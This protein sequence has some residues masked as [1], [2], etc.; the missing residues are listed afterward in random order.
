ML[1]ARFG[2][3]LT[4]HPVVTSALMLGLMIGIAWRYQGQVGAAAETQQS[5]RTAARRAQT[6]Q[7]QLAALMPQAMPADG[8]PQLLALLETSLKSAGAGERALG[9]VATSSSGLLPGV[10][11]IREV[12]RLEIRDLT[13][14]QAQVA[15]SAVES[16]KF[17][18]WVE[19]A[20]LVPATKDRWQLTLEVAW[21]ANP[22][23]AR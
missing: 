2:R 19:T 18:C 5:T 3:P 4:A 9:S 10:N 12:M 1:L 13:L 11:W 16:T 22:A 20:E 17:P 23:T 6:A 15:L 21:V 14:S 8:R 7:R